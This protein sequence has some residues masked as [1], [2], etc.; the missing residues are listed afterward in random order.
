M[1]VDERGL[2]GAGLT[3]GDAF[4][5]IVPIDL[6]LNIL[7]PLWRRYMIEGVEGAAKTAKRTVVQ[8]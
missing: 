3:L 1:A 2:G 8:A 6:A 5:V 7:A 4:R